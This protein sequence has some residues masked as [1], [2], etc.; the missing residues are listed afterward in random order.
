MQ[1]FKQREKTDSDIKESGD[2][3]NE[4][5]ATHGLLKTFDK[6]AEA[7]T[8]HE[9]KKTGV[10]SVEAIEETVIDQ[11]VEEEV[12]EEVED[13]IEESEAE[14]VGEE[15]ETEE[16]EETEESEE[17]DETDKSKKHESLPPK[18]QASID[19]R[20]AK[21][22]AKRKAI[23]DEVRVM[24]EQLQAKAPVTP[25]N[26]HLVV[27]E[28]WLVRPDTRE[29]VEMP[30]AANYAD[31]VT[32][33]IEDM[34]K[35]NNLRQQ[36]VH[37]V[38]SHHQKQTSEQYKQQRIESDYKP[39]MQA[40]LDKYNDFAQA[41]DTQ[42]Q[43]EFEAAHTWAVDVL[44]ESEY[45]PDIV[46]L[47]SKDKDLLREMKTMSPPQVAKTI[48]KLEAKLEMSVKPR[49]VSSAP[50]PISSASRTGGKVSASTK[51]RSE[52]EMSIKELKEQDRQKRFGNRRP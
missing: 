9:A 27:G 2:G 38:T 8:K 48:G 13:A 32:Q 33:Y 24:R 7:I 19:K 40:A 42:E 6:L 18:I 52:Q 10:K 31:N 1:Q 35:F 37:A 21:E 49:S 12:A 46:Y 28:D 4:K 20:I 34:T 22:V 3:S 16:V 14:E 36:V 50:K 15:S 45:G 23:E 29:R 25:P 11:E 41:V 39:R 17:E 5:L 47:L 30:R 51:V 26:L 43:R 44:K